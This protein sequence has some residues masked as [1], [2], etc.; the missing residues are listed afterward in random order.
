MAKAYTIV[1]DTTPNRLAKWLAM[2]NGRPTPQRGKEARTFAKLF[3]WLAFYE[4]ATLTKEQAKQAFEPLVT[5]TADAKKTKAHFY[6]E[7]AIKA[8]I[9]A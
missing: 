3:D 2:S 4:G 6:I 8:G 1:Q 7:Y 9:M 5:A